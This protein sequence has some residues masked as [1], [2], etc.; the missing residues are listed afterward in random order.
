M[1]DTVGHFKKHFDRISVLL[2]LVLLLLP[3]LPPSSVLLG[4]VYVVNM[5]ATQWTSGVEMLTRKPRAIMTRIKNEY[6]DLFLDD[7]REAC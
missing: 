7:H 3:L 6:T 4:Y 5:Y 1:G 2:L